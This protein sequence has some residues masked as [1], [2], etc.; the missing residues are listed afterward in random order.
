AND[1]LNISVSGIKTLPITAQIIDISGRVLISKTFESSTVNDRFNVGELNNG[2]YFCNFY[3]ENG[4]KT[5][6]FVVSK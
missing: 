4:S 2:I 3:S 5:I 1:Q 6:K